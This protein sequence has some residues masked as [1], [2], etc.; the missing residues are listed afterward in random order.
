MTLSAKPLGAARFTLL[1]T[2]PA[3]QA[4]ELNALV[5]QANGLVLPCPLLQIKSH[6]MT[7]QQWQ[8][9]LACTKVILTSV[10]AVQALQQGAAAS[11]ND[12]FASDLAQRFAPNTQFFAIGAATRQA[13][14]D[15]GLP[16]QDVQELALESSLGQSSQPPKFDSET[17]LAHPSMHA[18]Q[19]GGQRIALIKGVGG[20]ELIAATL[21]ARGASVQAFT[22]YERECAP[23]NT[24]VW[25]AFNQAK[26]PILL[27]TSW[28]GFECLHRHVPNPAGTLNATVVFGERIAHNLQQMGW[29]GMIEVCAPSQFA[30]VEAIETIL[31]RVERQTAH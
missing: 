17:L 29:P 21:T 31:E 28:E 7:S 1:N 23:F 12:G 13:G 22:V 16:M 19:V 2:R 27:L 5:A 10:N 26:N 25:H 4:A 18:L 11:T 8:S 24:Q 14:L 30:I 15:A 20:R 6:P 9:M 3:H